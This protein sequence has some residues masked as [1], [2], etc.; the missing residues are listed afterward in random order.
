M[1]DAKVDPLSWPELHSFDDGEL[2]HDMVAAILAMEFEAA[3]VDLHDLSIVSGVGSRSDPDAKGPFTL[4][5]DVTSRF[6]KH[7]PTES[8][9]AAKERRTRGGPWSLRVPEDQIVDL[10][11]IAPCCIQLRRGLFELALERRRYAVHLVDQRI[12]H[13]RLGTRR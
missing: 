5:S 12:V 6:S 7:V 10:L 11:S 3:L 8:E 13:R 9:R 2:A 4:E 1:N